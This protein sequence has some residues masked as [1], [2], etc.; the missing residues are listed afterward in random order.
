MGLLI[1]YGALAL[2]FA[3]V[4]QIL[5][6]SYIAD[7]DFTD[8]AVAGRSFSGFYQAM[9]FLNT[10]LPGYVYLGLFG[11]T[12]SKGVIGMGFAT[13][14]A[15]LVMYLMADRV[16]TWG[17]THNLRTQPDLMALRFDSKGVRVIA[18]LL[19]I[20]GL[21]P[22]MVLGMQSL[23]AVFYAL[24]LDRLSFT[25]SVVLGVVVMTVRQIWTIR[26]GM[27]GIVISDLLHFSPL[28]GAKPQE[29]RMA[30]FARGRPFRE[31]DLG[32]EPWLYPRC[33]ALIFDLRGERRLRRDERLGLLV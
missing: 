15:P 11:F 26:M 8:F 17:A 2:F 10:G 4:V 20:F 32:D 31:L 6:R 3:V 28:V 7:R 16:W 25:Q 12:A 27:R 19:G 29:H 22:W 21:M 24:S 30:H 1:T 33:Y 18:A 5:Q 13:V 14:L 9:A 23:G